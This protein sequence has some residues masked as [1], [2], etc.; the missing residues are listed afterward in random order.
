MNNFEF[1]ELIEKNGL[2]DKANILNFDV[3][4]YYQ[5]ILNKKSEKEEANWI[6]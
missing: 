6:R 4:G 3:D 5:M 2:I 1:T